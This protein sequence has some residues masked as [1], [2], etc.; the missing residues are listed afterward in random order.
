MNQATVEAVTEEQIPSAEDS[1]ELGHSPCSG[2]V[3]LWGELKHKD[4]GHSPGDRCSGKEELTGRMEDSELIPAVARN[5]DPFGGD[6]DS[7]EDSEQ[8]IDEGV[9]EGK[10]LW[11][12]CWD[13][14]GIVV[15]EG[16]EYNELVSKDGCKS[17]SDSWKFGEPQ[18]DSELLSQGLKLFSLDNLK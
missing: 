8:A 10:V 7:N 12:I 18:V 5:D 3:R 6:D 15:F 13:G 14:E 9:N 4:G 1:G 11:R 16:H 2:G 17:A